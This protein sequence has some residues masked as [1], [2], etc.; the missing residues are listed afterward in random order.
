MY[1]PIGPGCRFFS[2]RAAMVIS[3][4][5]AVS[6]RA[7][8]LGSNAKILRFRVTGSGTKS[9]FAGVAGT[10]GDGR[11]PEDGVLTT[12]VLSVY[13][14]STVGKGYYRG[15]ITQSGNSFIG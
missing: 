14:Q 13:P 3:L 10:T 8:T 2:H 11:L 7:E 1:S 6:T 15:R 12:M 9:L 5:P 4:I